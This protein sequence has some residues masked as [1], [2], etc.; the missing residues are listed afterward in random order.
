MTRMIAALTVALATTAVISAADW[1][2]WRGPGDTGVSMETNLPVTWSDTENVAWRAPLTGLG[3]STPVVW[4]D[5]I[6]V[7]SQTGNV[8][9]RTGNHPTLVT[10][11]ALATS[12]ERTLGGRRQ[13]ERAR[14]DDT[15]RFILTALDRASGKRLWEHTVDAEGPLPEVHEKHNL[16]SPSPATDGTRVYAWY[17]TGQLIAVDMSGKR[18]WT[19]N[20]A[21]DIAPVSILWG[22]GS[23]PAVYGDSVYLLSYHGPTAYLMAVD[24]ATGKTK[25]KVDGSPSVTSYSTPVMVQA[26]TGRELIVNSSEGV[27]GHNPDT[28]ERLWFYPEANSFPVPA[29][30]PAGG[31]LIYL[32]RGY[33]SSP[34][35]A[36]RA[37]GRGNITDTHVVWRQA[38]SGPY[39]PSLV[40]YQGLLY[41]ATDAGIVSAIDAATGERV[42]QE[43][44][45]GVYMASPVAGD[46][47]IYFADETGMTLV[48]EA[49]R[50]LKVLAKNRLTGRFG[51]SPAIAGGR[52]FLRSDDAV[53]AVG[54]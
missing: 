29:P 23:S 48:L 16:A 8:A 27:A 51:A 34:Y 40:H 26:P 24:A 50:T 54:K 37:G 41:M 18:V 4:G 17:G 11:A 52:I 20:L 46:G 15:V 35:M 5:R 32:N 13:G 14:A 12:G 47:K 1:P 9:E 22:P 39:V 36:I 49:G 7:T 21:K 30:V 38:T 43:R 53:V 33:R 42:W 10:G 19:R 45:P 44:I 6:F 3:V 31:G 28:G 2:A 25:W